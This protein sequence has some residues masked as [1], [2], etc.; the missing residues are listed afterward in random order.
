MKIA[1]LVTA[2]KYPDQVAGLTRRLASMFPDSSQH[3]HVDAKFDIAPFVAAA[4][5]RD[6]D[7][8]FL[9]ARQRV[10]WGAFSAVRSIMALADA[11]LASDCDRAVL[12]SEQCYPIRPARDLLAHLERNHD[13]EFVDVRRL[14]TDWP[15]A[16]ERYDRYYFPDVKPDWVC[17]LAERVANTAR[18]RRVPPDGLELFG[19]STWWSLTRDALLHL[20]APET[21]QRADRYF[22]TTAC[23]D[24]VY[25]QTLLMNEPRFASRIAPPLTYVRFDRAVSADHPVVWTAADLPELAA[26]GCYFARKFDERV[27]ATPFDALDAVV[28]A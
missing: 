8:Q 15:A 17:N 10:H 5:H 1:F 13:R 19:G 25:V 7:V 20:R 11:A 6:V 28:D 16:L 4:A 12:L 3:V 9:Q 14:S 26:S 18:P 2:Y 21:R 22:R 24:E 23:A 27:D